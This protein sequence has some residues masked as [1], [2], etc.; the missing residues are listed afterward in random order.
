MNTL[1]L[2]PW[3]NDHRSRTDDGLGP[4][5][6]GLQ[7]D[8]PA[9]RQKYFLVSSVIEVEPG[10]S[11]SFRE[12][13]EDTEKVLAQI[14]AEARRAI[15]NRKDELVQEYE[16]ISKTKKTGAKLPTT[17]CVMYTPSKLFISSS[18]RKSPA[19]S[20]TNAIQV[21]EPDSLDMPREWDIFVKKALKESELFDEGEVRHQ[22]KAN[23]AEMLCLHLWSLCETSRLEDLDSCLFVTVWFDSEVG[24][25]S[26]KRPCTGEGCE[27]VL[28]GLQ[29]EYGVKFVKELM[30]PEGNW[31]TDYLGLKHHYSIIPKATEAS[32]WGKNG[33]YQEPKGVII[34][35]RY[36][37]VDFEN[38]RL[39]PR[40]KD[41]CTIGQ[42]LEL[43]LDEDDDEDAWWV[44]EI[45]ASEALKMKV[46][47]DA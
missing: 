27:K 15:K 29:R 14:A 13:V 7:V 40:Q 17:L 46:C 28:E 9:A 22:T 41:L 19:A 21:T 10:C 32:G 25:V 43:P 35:G 16:R 44:P 18:V 34:R 11:L 31:Q 3:E 4:I 6:L 26:I 24:D 36:I 20:W 37:G 1:R 12:P 39:Q 23:C 8:Q 30:I 33:L 47:P 5:D 2:V 38:K 45:P 42:D